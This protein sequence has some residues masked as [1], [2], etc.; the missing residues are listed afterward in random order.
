LPEGFNALSLVSVFAAF[1]G[2]ERCQREYQQKGRMYTTPA[3]AYEH[4]N[5]IK[6]KPAKAL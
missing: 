3:N 4:A 2:M 1:A 5:S 6:V